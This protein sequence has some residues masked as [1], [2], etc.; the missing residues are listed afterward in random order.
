MNITGT[1]R[2]FNIKLNLIDMNA[3]DFCQSHRTTLAREKGIKFVIA[4]TVFHYNNKYTH[5]TV[6]EVHC[7]GS[8][9]V[10]ASFT[11]EDAVEVFNREV[12]ER[13][14]KRT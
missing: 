11:F 14:I 4:V 1:P 8:Q 5:E 3:I 7:K 9:A 13:T 2:S 10:F 6:F 12:N